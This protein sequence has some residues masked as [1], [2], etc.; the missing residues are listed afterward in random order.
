MYD[1]NQVSAHSDFATHS[2][3]LV[4]SFGMWGLVIGCSGERAIDVR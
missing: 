4:G 3:E 2:N 1:E